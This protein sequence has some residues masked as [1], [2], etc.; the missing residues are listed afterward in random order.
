MR[1]RVRRSIVCDVSALSEPNLK[2]I[3]VLARLQLCARRR[4]HELRLHEP[5]R[6]LDH[7]IAFVGL[8]EC[9]RVEPRRQ[10]EEREDALGVEEEGELDDP[11][12]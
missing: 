10:A 6:N 1:E 7:L 2:T 8:G 9:L 4:G 5:S 11:S 3:D 12:L